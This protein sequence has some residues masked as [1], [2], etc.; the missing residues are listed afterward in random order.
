MPLQNLKQYVLE[1]LWYFLGLFPF[2]SLAG[3]AVLMWEGKK[4]PMIRIAAATVISG[5]SGVVVAAFLWKQLAEVDPFKLT[6]I[7]ILAGAGG[8]TTMDLLLA[9]FYRFVKK[10]AGLEEDSKQQEEK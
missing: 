2:C 9:G 7:S 6:A 4:I 1:Q 8:A 3:L 10:R 5:I